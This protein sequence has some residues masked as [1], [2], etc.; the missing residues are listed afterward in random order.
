MR[1]RTG[2]LLLGLLLLAVGGGSATVWR[3]QQLA[4]QAGPASELTKVVIAPGSSLRSVLTQLQQQGLVAHPRLLEYYLRVQARVQ[5]AAMPSLHAGHYRLEPGLSPLL[6]LQQL[7]E[8][9]VYL[10]Q[11]TIVEGWNLRQLRAALDAL[12]LLTHDSTGLDEA[13]LRQALAAPGPS[14]EGWFAPDT[15]RFEEQSSDL[16]ILRMAHESQQRRLQRAWDERNE[17][18]PLATPE[19]ALTLASIIE[20]ETSL[21]SERPRI[22]GVFINRLRLGMRLQTDPTVIYG[23][24]E[25]YDGDIRTRDLR[26]DTPYNTYTR[27]GLPPTPIAMPGAAAIAAAVHPQSSKELYFVS[28]ADGSGGHQFSSTLAEH[29]AAVSR[30]LQRLRAPAAPR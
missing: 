27:S 6:Q 7:Q 15:Y 20:K 28:L 9:R 22:A 2:W 17:G 23:L 19:Q 25:A 21:P 16:T 11:F 18:L 3:L 1:T 4:L 24:G 14:L 13:A 8:G 10:E 5:Q 30:Y 12:P 26:T 29:N